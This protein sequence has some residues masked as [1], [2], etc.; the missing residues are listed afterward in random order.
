MTSKKDMIQDNRAEERK[1]KSKW[2]LAG[3]FAWIC[4]AS[5]LSSGNCQI[6]TAFYSNITLAFNNMVL[7]L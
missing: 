3:N 2:T 5:Y 7:Q 4:K 1:D 6:Y